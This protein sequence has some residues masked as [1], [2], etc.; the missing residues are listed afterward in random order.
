M[1]L[2]AGAAEIGATQMLVTTRF[3]ATDVGGGLGGWARVFA[4][5]PGPRIIAAA[6]LVVT[7][8]RVALWRWH[9]WDLVIVA[10]FFVGLLLAS[11]D[12]ILPPTTVA[13]GPTMWVVV[14]VDWVAPPLAGFKFA[15]DARVVLAF[16][17]V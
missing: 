2:R 16:Q 12:H 7:T 11:L 13:T 4:G 6:L 17:V 3:P 8:A 9:W 14:F 10:G 1:G 5:Y 15:R